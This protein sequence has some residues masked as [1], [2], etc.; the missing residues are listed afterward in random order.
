VERKDELVLIVDLPGVKKEDIELDVTEDG[1]EI[2]ASAPSGQIDGNYIKRER[3]TDPYHRYV[4]LDVPVTPERTHASYE[5]GILTIRF[6]KAKSR[7]L[8]VSVA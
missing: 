4:H 1:C 6:E 5:N 2:S 8:S 3:P 7:G